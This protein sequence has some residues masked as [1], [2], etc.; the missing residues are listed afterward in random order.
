MFKKTLKDLTLWFKKKTQ[1]QTF[2]SKKPEIQNKTRQIK[3]DERKLK[4]KKFTKII[5]INRSKPDMIFF[6]FF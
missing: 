4:K 2:D 6:Y 3:K 5:L 1:S